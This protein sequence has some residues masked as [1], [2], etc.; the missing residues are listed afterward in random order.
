MFEKKSLIVGMALGG[1]LVLSGMMLGGLQQRPPRRPVNEFEAELIKA[2][3]IQLVRPDGR[4][5]ARLSARQTTGMIN[6][7][8]DLGNENVRLNSVLRGGGVVAT[9]EDGITMV[10]LGSTKQ[11]GEISVSRFNEHDMSATG[12]R[13]AADRLVGGQIITQNTEGELS[14]TLPE[15]LFELAEEAKARRRAEQNR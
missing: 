15:N 2:R 4:A 7:Y 11:G 9:L 1:A 8:D 10:T 14:S 12:V 13:I 3:E 6:I 5:M